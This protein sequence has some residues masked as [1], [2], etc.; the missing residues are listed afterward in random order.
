MIVEGSMVLDRAIVPEDN[1]I[2]PPLNPTMR[3]NRVRNMVIQ[4][5]QQALTLTRR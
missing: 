1:C 2:G 3:F 5:F 4:Q